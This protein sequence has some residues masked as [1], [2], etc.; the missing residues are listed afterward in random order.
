MSRPIAGGSRQAE[1][2]PRSKQPTIVIE[3][4]HRLV[5]LADTVDWTELEARAEIIRASKLKNAAGR[6]PH[7]RVML[8]AMLLMATRKMTY[9][10]AE[11]QIRHYAP[12]RYLCGLTETEWTPDF[13]TIQDFTELMGE[14]G[15]RLINEYAVE[16]AVEEKLADP[17]LMVADTTAQEAAIPW[18]N[19]MGLMASFLSSVAAASKKAGTALKHFAQKMVDKFK[20]GREKVRKYR[21]FAKTK[22]ARL[23][24][25]G[26][27]AKLVGE[28]QTRLGGALKNSTE[29][30][31]VKYGKVAQAKAF[32][33]HET[34]A[35]LL[36][37]IWYWH[38]TGRVAANKIINLHIPELYSIVRG[39]VG[40][41]V[42]FGL[43]WGITRLRGG[44]LL[45]TVAK[46]RRELVD[47]KFAL[48][49]VDQHIALFGKAPKSYAYDRAGYSRK[50][51]IELRKKGV[52]QVGL[53]PL[54]QAAWE[55]SEPIKEKLI[56]ERA[57][58]EGGIGAIKS[59]RYGFN[60]PSARSAE[61]MGACGQRAV[62]GF[63]L[64]KL[65]RE[66]AKRNEVVLAG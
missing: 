50:N 33:L 18:P 8:G 41:A 38:Q 28:V 1:L 52:K 6:P 26:E 13:T 21:L 4:N 22:K 24:V 3:E 53:A 49:A 15:I 46:D 61:M 12:A 51:V 45:A 16:L 66:M 60:R 40:K 20:A 64:N 29:S 11:D 25:M 55:V 19:E 47:A 57:Q 37:Q 31:L 5:H 30:R 9:R 10:E 36:P 62:L 65:V 58:V 44:F 54:G 48:R 39:K 7:L 43:T 59:N 42:E 35:K 17:K 56:K 23:Q 32:R 14:E 63:N 34:M 27:M 2:F